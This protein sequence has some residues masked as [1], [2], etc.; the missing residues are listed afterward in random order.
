MNLYMGT[1]LFHIFIF[2]GFLFLS[3]LA[4]IAEFIDRKVVA[5]M[6]NRVGP[7]WY[8]PLADFLK[9]IGKKA[10]LPQNAKVYIFKLLPV[11]SL[12]AVA[13]AYINVP[14][15]GQNAVKAFDGD[16]IIL[17]YMLLIPTLCLFLAG[18]N[19]HDVFT[20]TGA[21]RTL[22]QMFA[23]EV[24]LFI[25]FLAPAMLAKS[26][27]VTG[28]CA[29]YAVHPL[30]TLFNIPAFL[31]ALITAQAKLERAPFDAPDAETEIVGGTLVEYSG[32]YLAAFH[33]AADCEFIVVISIIAALFLPYA[34][35]IVWIDFLLYLIKL[36][37]LTLALAAMRAVMA[38]IRI[39]QMLH[40]C[41]KVLTPVAIGQM[42]LN[43]ILKG[44][45]A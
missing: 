14:V 34:T 26:W 27:S 40:F 41:W 4:F 17:L 10:I 8:Q 9:L 44:W 13:T 2:P 37:A 43:L 24:P 21:F 20:V 32:R 18:W 12:A 6:Q 38:R 23:Y 5:R 36:L 28:I 15:W 31:V 45:V 1:A 3:A 7:P 35:G 30:Y 29:Y 33:V 25:V 22:T 16:L 39:D 19:S 11:I 42:I